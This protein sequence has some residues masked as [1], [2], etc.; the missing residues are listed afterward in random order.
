L[1]HPLFHINHHLPSGAGTIG[2]LVVYVTS[3]LG[4]TP[5]QET[6]KVNIK[7]IFFSSHKTIH[8]N[9][10]VPAQFLADEDLLP[11]YSS[12]YFSL[13]YIPYRNFLF[14]TELLQQLIFSGKRLDRSQ[15]L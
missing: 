1:L 5:P 6:K 2:K 11:E 7:T 8:V 15:S 12:S 4:H 9:K 10:S 14:S 3:G 13:V